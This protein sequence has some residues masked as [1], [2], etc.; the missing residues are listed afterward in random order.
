MDDITRKEYKI[1]LDEIKKA[2]DIK[3]HV[4]EVNTEFQHGTYVFVI[5]MVKDTIEKPYTSK[6]Q[7]GTGVKK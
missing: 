1:T 5:K 7:S 2:F 4:L 6:L 3:G